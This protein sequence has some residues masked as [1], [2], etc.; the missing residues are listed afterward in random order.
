MFFRL[1]LFISFLFSAGISFAQQSEWFWVNPRPIGTNLNDAL[2]LENKLIAFADGG[3]VLYS[4]DG[5]NTGIYI[6]PDS[7]YGNRSIY[8]ADFVSAD[9]GYLC[10]LSGL[11]MKTIDGGLTWTHLT[12]PLTSNLWYIDFIDADTGYVVSSDSRVIKTT[13]GGQNWTVNQIYSTS[14]TLYKIYFVSPSTGYLGTGNATLGRLL[15]TTDYGATWLPVTSYTSTGTVRGI[16]FTDELTGYIGNTLYEILKTTDGGLSWTTQDMGTGTVYEIKFFDANNGAAAGA[17]GT[18]FFTT[19]AGTTWQPTSIGFSTNCNIYGLAMSN[20][21]ADIPNTIFAAAQSGIMAKSSNMGQTWIPISEAATLHNLRS[22]RM[23]NN[24]TGYAVGGSTTESEVIKTTDGGLTWDKV[25]FDAGYTLYAQSWIDQN[26]GFV[27]RRGPDGIFKTTD[28]GANFTQLN[29]GVVTST[30]IW[31]DIE[32]ANADTGYAVSSGG[33][34]V[35]TTDGGTSWAALPAVHGTSAIYSLHILDAENIFA[36]GVSGKVSKSTDGG[37][38]FTAI[39]I[40]G[41]TTLYSVSFIDRNNGLAAGT[42]GKVFRTT[43]GGTSWTELFAGTSVTLYDI[44]YVSPSIIWISGGGIFYS[45][46]GG[47]TWTEADKFHGQ[48]TYY[49]MAIAGDKL[50]TAGGFG[51]ILGTSSNPIPVELT[52]FTAEQQGTAVNLIWSTATETNNSGFEIQRSNDQISWGNI[53]FI[54]GNGTTSEKQYY[55]FTDMN[56][57]SGKSYYRLK[58]IDYNGQ[59]EYS[60]VVMITIIQVFEFELQQNYP[61]PFNPSTVI[62]YQ[63]PFDGMVTLKVYDILGN[64]IQTLV[65]GYKNAGKYSAAFDGSRLSSGIYLIKMKSG[66]FISTRKMTLIK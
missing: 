11:L 37:T 3:C 20:S 46:D 29:P 4:A 40:T 14:T 51:N 32:F 39:N 36:A 45:T 6:Y 35:R 62:N 22:I 15:K 31:Y 16:Y 13:D 56:V 1:L 52:L 33:H 47:L 57:P 28:G 18:V 12:S 26:T 7:L 23:A 63:I 9:T 49:S 25:N 24:M 54:P 30:Q 58:Q 44:L 8:E 19:D 60:P 41:T 42:S 55:S 38:T 50:M 17:L 59:F 27:A 48:N 2:I 43:D 53:A 34:I 66:D 10:G 64:E 5:G 21:F 61:N 65:N